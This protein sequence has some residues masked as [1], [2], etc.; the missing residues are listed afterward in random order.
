[1][2]GPLLGLAAC[3]QLAAASSCAGMMP[4]APPMAQHGDHQPI[5]DRGHD[6]PGPCHAAMSCAAHK[7]SDED[8]N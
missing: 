8:G 5:K 2:I 1:M 3:A 4:M 6:M 7:R